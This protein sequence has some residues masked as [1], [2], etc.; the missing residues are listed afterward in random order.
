MRRAIQ[1]RKIVLKG[2][3]LVGAVILMAACGYVGDTLPPALYIP[4]PV[5][6]LSALQE[7]ADV[8][9]RF[10]MPTRSTEDLPLDG[11]LDID[12]RAAVWENRDWDDGAWERE[13]QLLPVAV[14]DETGLARTPVNGFIGKRLLLRVRVAGPKKRF[15]AWSA[16]AA[17]RVLGPQPK[18]AGVSATAT[19]EGVAVAWG[20]PEPSLGGGPRVVEVWRRQGAESEFR[21]V[22]TPETSPF[23]DEGSIFGEPHSYRLRTRVAAAEQLA[24]SPFTDAV[25]VIP[26]DTFPPARPVDLAA[27]AGVSSIELSWSRNS[28]ADL[29]GYRVYRAV[30]EAEFLPI[31]ELVPSSTYSDASAPTGVPLRYRITALDATGNESEP[32]TAVEATLP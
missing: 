7:G 18:P 20:L 25:N 10:T 32:A 30:G 31:G 19:A 4:I 1:R 29:E 13:A 2:L 28:E 24:L 27:I 9:V 8:V 21:L 6:D 5:E 26:V 16:P 22:G 12:L 3:L 11:S 23:V 17:L 15:S 14:D